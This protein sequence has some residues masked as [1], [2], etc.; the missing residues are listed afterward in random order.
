MPRSKSKTKALAAAKCNL[1]RDR[2]WSEHRRWND[3]RPLPPIAQEYAENGGRQQQQ[4][5]DSSYNAMGAMS[6][7]LPY[8]QQIVLQSI[9]YSVKLHKYN[10]ASLQYFYLIFVNVSSVT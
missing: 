2:D 4:E 9:D 8:L 10:D 3:L 7:S 5:Y 1:H 6:T